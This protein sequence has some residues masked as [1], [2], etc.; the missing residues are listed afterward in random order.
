MGTSQSSPGA[1]SG[2]SLIPPWV[3]SVG[4]PDGGLPPDGQAQQAPQPPP[5]A[6]PVAPPKRFQQARTNFGK[7][8]SDGAS[9]H[10]QRALG[11]YVR[12]GYGG[13]SGAARRMGSSSAVAGALYGA[14]S[15]LA[16][17]PSG[18]FSGTLDRHLLQGRSFG[19]V[20]DALVNSVCSHTGTQDAESARRS[21]HDALSRLYETN[22]NADLLNL[23]EDQ[24]FAVIEEFLTCEVTT[25]FLLDCEASIKARAPIDVALDRIR[26]AKDYIRSVIQNSLSQLR[27]SQ[28]TSIDVSR[29]ADE[30]FRLTFSVFEEY[31]L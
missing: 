4:P 23:D 2:V 29:T 30:T 31:I 19:E 9:H 20:S 14:L 28:T 1:P 21:I 24:R 18:E 17:G 10:L 22:P 3:P 6:V 13:S 15:A 7:F 27:E 8:A 26:Q 25:R 16:G 12:K 11:G 5:A